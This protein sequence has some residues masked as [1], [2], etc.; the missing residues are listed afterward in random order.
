MTN[1]EKINF[2]QIRDFGETF[3]V[4]VKFIKQ[5]FKLFFF[6]I[7]SIA[8]PFILIS[9]IAGAFYQSNSMGAFSIA[10]M[11]QETFFEQ[12]GIFFLIFLLS[13]VLSNLMLI[14]TTFSYMINYMEK[15]PGNFTI[16]DVSSLL[17]KNG[18]RIF[19]TFLFLILLLA[20]I[21][22]VIAGIVAALAF[23]KVQVLIVLF[24]LLLIFGLIIVMPPLFWQLSSIYLIVMQEGKGIFAS[25][26]RTFKVMRGNFWWTWVIMICTILTIG[27]ASLV[28]TLPQLI[29][30]MV[31]MFSHLKPDAVDEGTSIPFIIVASVCTF[32]S[33]ILYSVLYIIC[34][35]HYYSLAEQKDGTGLIERINEIGN[36]PNTNAE[37]YY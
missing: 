17:I 36:T 23:S 29:Y 10:R 35:F 30:Q 16:A 12:Y 26:V 22:G 24:V 27:I 32:F 19:L 25:F 2:R 14:G 21:I 33:T 8:G 11:G 28:F 5:N 18:L 3:N 7:I 4:S 37:Q 20:L 6:S 1:Q 31:I 15:G 13:S 9:A 34:G